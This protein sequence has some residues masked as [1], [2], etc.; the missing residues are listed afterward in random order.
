MKTSKPD[1]DKTKSKNQKKSPR[2]IY[3]LRDTHISVHRNHLKTPPK[4]LL[5]LFWVGHLLENTNSSF[6]SGYLLELEIGSL[7]LASIF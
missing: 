4:I 1:Y 5:S 2:N 7:L 6:A 3:R